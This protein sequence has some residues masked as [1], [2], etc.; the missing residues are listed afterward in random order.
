MR[1]STSFDAYV[2]WDPLHFS[3]PVPATLGARAL[4]WGK[5]LSSFDPRISDAGLAGVQEIQVYNQELARP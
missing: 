5:N 1:S 3:F 4:E 2:E